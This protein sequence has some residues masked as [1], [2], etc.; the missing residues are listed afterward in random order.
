MAAPEEP[1]SP[2]RAS[3]LVVRL[4]VYDFLKQSD[5]VGGSLLSMLGMG[6]H[7]SGL[8]IEDREYTFNNSGIIR[9]RLLRMPFCRLN[10]SIELGRYSGSHEELEAVIS[11][12]GAAEWKPGA[13]HVLR[14]NCNHFTD[15]LARRLL[16][17]SI[18]SWVNRS[19][20]MASVFG[21]TTKGINSSITSVKGEK[22]PPKVDA[23]PDPPVAALDADES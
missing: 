20:N 15:T 7:H 21:L 4:N 19:A 13:Y 2:G 16:G 10:E 8:Q 18:P 9:M 23:D 11:E 6:I 1:L 5:T 3:H 22:A 14:R 12:L 17:A